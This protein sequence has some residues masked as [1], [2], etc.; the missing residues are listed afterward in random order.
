MPD[1]DVELK[2]P[3]KP[4]DSEYTEDELAVLGGA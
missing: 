1:K 3:K 4:D 2:P